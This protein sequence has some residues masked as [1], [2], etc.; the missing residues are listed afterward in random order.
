MDDFITQFKK[1]L[2]RLDE[3]EKKRGSV[4]ESN[5]ETGPN[6][7]TGTIIIYPIDTPPSGYLLCD[8]ASLLRADYPDLFNVIGVT[9][10]SVDGDHFNIP[11]L[12]GK[13]IVGK[14]I[15]QTE[16][17]VLGKTGGEKTHTLTV[18]EL[19]NHTH[20]SVGHGY[21]P[22]TGGPLIATQS[23]SNWGISQGYTGGNQP[24]NNLQPYIV[25]NFMIKT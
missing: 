10:G 18:A 22:Y 6:V 17:N 7:E 2:E 4:G 9:Y 8:G 1:V 24:H 19:A 20:Y 21:F 12:K 15:T 25:L 14:D 11:N 23:T 5:I 3:L 16:F 13:V